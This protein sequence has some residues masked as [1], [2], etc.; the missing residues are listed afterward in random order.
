MKKKSMTKKKKTFKVKGDM[1]YDSESDLSVH[2]ESFDAT[3]T[4]RSPRAAAAAAK[5]RVAAVVKRETR[6]KIGDSDDESNVSD[7]DYEEETSNY[8]DDSKGEEDIATTAK[9]RRGIKKS[10]K[11]VQKYVNHNDDVPEDDDTAIERARSRQAV[12]L[13]KAKWSKKSGKSLKGKKEKVTK[14]KKKTVPMR[15]KDKK[16]GNQAGGLSNKKASG[17]PPTSS[18][19]DSESVDDASLNVDMDVLIAEAME[20]C[21][22][23]VLHSFCWWRVVLDEA[24][25]I[26]SRSSQTSAAAFALTGIHRW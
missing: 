15:K 17:S 9:E 18:D 13:V 23:S 4:F 3:K 20:G 1:E 6:G 5:S 14:I 22:L 24:H 21:R 7:D 11:K 25:F 26:K 12:A 10:T 2:S 8:E 16:Q 19:D